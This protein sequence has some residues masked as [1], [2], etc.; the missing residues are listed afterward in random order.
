MGLGNAMARLAPAA[1][2]LV[3][4]C[5]P[6][7]HVGG[8]VGS[9][10]GESAFP[11]IGAGFWRAEVSTQRFLLGRVPFPGSTVSSQACHAD[12]SLL[13][14]KLGVCARYAL[15][16][17]PDG[18]FVADMA[19]RDETGAWRGRVSYAGDFA[20]SFTQESWTEAGP[21]QSD[22]QVS[23]VVAVYTYVGSCPS[24]AKPVGW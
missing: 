17:L 12:S 7:S 20:R 1:A 18:T 13:P 4:A 22:P 19:C 23:H 16:R 15:G 3:A 14:P 10:I 9:M 21:G 11:H 24:G 8:P 2:G 6:P 5:S